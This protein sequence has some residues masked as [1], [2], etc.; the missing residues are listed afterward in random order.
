[1]GAWA[2]LEEGTA[3]NGRWREADPRG[4]ATPTRR[5]AS[6]SQP[7]RFP[8]SSRGAIAEDDCVKGAVG[9]RF[10][11]SCTT[12]AENR[13]SRIPVELHGHEDSQP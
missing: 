1:M 8:G 3:G 7:T 12:P 5:E 6:S 4:V 10:D 9:T 2:V 11:H 13:K